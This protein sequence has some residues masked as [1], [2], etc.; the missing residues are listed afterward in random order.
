MGLEQEQT[1]VLFLTGFFV[2]TALPDP[3]H[4][5]RKAQRHRC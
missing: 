3:W 2:V 1:L 4:W 5:M